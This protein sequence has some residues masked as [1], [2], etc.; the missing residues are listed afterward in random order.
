MGEVPKEKASKIY[1]VALNEFINNDYKS[2]S[3]NIIA[4]KS[5]ISKGSLFNYYG[6]KLNLFLMVAEKALKKYEEAMMPMLKDLS[7]DIFERVYET[8]M[9]KMELYYKLPKENRMIMRLFLTDDI[10]IRK[11]LIKYYEYYEKIANNTLMCDIDNSKFKEGIDPNTVYK[12]LLY[13]SYGF[14]E[15]LQRKYKDE[16]NGFMRDIDKISEELLESINLI[17]L[18]VYK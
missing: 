16:P 10:E 14:I 6:N 9:I 11:K 4:R 12:T 13:I 1:D 3:T 17:K 18:S 15:M 8:Q 2:A 7:T 5:G